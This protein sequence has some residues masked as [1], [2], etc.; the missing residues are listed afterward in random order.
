MWVGVKSSPELSYRGELDERAAS[1]AVDVEVGDLSESRESCLESIGA[2]ARGHK[3][4]ICFSADPGRHRRGGR[5]ISCGINRSFES[6]SLNSSSISISLEMDRGYAASY[7]IRRVSSSIA[8][9]YLGG[10]FSS[11]M[12]GEGGRVNATCKKELALNDVAFD[13]G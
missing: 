6:T 5:W 13:E 10:G 3:W 4:D 2:D 1:M 9:S 8:E 12:D 7:L 11:T